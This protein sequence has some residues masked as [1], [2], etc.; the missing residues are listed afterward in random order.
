M[1]AATLIQPLLKGLDQ[2]A[3]TLLPILTQ[4]IAKVQ[5]LIDP[6]MSALTKMLAGV[7]RRCQ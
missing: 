1:R 6:L 5:P 3:K 2:M 4:I 7:P